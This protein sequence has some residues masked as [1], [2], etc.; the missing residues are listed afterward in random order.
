MGWK[1]PDS[2]NSGR[3]CVCFKENPG[4]NK[5]RTTEELL[6]DLCAA[7]RTIGEA[8][9]VAHVI[10]DRATKIQ[11]KL[12]GKAAELKQQLLRRINDLLVDG[13]YRP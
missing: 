6:E 10:G 12:E 13:S 1:M 11:K 9:I 2:H 7:E 3:D 5:D 8:E 4:K